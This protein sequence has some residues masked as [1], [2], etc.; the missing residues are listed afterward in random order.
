M[1]LPLYVSTHKTRYQMFSHRRLR[2]VQWSN[3]NYWRSLSIVQN[4]NAKVGYFLDHRVIRFPGSAQH[5]W[6]GRGRELS[7]V[8]KVLL[9][10]TTAWTCSSSHQQQTI[11]NSWS[12]AI[13]S[14]IKLCP[15]SCTLWAAQPLTSL[16]Y[17]DKQP[18]CQT[19]GE[20]TCP[21]PSPAAW[22]HKTALQGDLVCG[23][24]SVPSL[25]PA[26]TD[27]AWLGGADSAC[28]SCLQA[29]PT[30][31]KPGDQKL[32]LPGRWMPSRAAGT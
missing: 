27:T 32:P 20:Q 17:L 24:C 28:F 10:S 31:G 13:N 9:L 19:P 15:S 6:C 18:C 14:D 3:R 5:Q 21:G 8:P 12:M 23:I 2:E 29:L 30:C 26:E 22:G 25:L 11:L 1:G 7:T 4:I 16:M